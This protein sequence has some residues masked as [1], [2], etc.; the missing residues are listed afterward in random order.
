MKAHGF[1]LLPT[2]VMVPWYFCMGAMGARALSNNLAIS[3]EGEQR[4]WCPQ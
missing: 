2:T 4:F 3:A 1:G